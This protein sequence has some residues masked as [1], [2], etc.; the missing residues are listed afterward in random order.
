MNEYKDSDGKTQYAPDN[1]TVK[2]DGKNV[3][4]IDKATGE[5]TTEKPTS[6]DKTPPSNS[7]DFKKTVSPTGDITYK[8]QD[9]TD[10]PKPKPKALEAVE[11]LNLAIAD[12]KS[13]KAKYTPAELSKMMKDAAKAKL[14]QNRK[15]EKTTEELDKVTKEAAKNAERKE[16]TVPERAAKEGGRTS[17]DRGAEGPMSP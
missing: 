1:Y 10:S 9:T 2:I 12:M 14:T 6:E 3:E 15:E 17:G 7:G 8:K 11:K 13:G 4:F 16:Q 5:S